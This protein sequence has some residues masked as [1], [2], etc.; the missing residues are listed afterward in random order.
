MQH[1]P[2]VVRVGR[3]F[4]LR[5]LGGLLRQLL[6]HCQVRSPSTVSHPASIDL[7]GG[8]DGKQSRWL[9]VVRGLV[10]GLGLHRHRFRIGGIKTGIVEAVVD[11]DRNR[12]QPRSASRQKLDHSNGARA[13]LGILRG[14]MVLIGRRRLLAASVVLQD[15]RRTAHSKAERRDRQQRRHSLLAEFAV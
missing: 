2:V 10:N 9:A 8:Y 15:L 4:L 6:I 14:T 7:L 1:W 3:S 13:T 5:L 11:P 12:D